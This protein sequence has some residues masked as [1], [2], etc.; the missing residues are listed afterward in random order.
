MNAGPAALAGKARRREEEKSERWV[1]ESDSLTGFQT[2]VTCRRWV[3]G[4]I[5]GMYPRNLFA[6]ESAERERLAGLGTRLPEA[7]VTGISKDM[8]VVIACRLRVMVN[9]RIVSH[10]RYLQDSRPPHTQAAKASASL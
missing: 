2:T 7:N 9:A 4:Y 6:L 5:G 10:R 1:L 8:G 3:W